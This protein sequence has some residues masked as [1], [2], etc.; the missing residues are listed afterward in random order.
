MKR[1]ETASDFHRRFTNDNSVPGRFN[2]YKK[3]PCSTTP[4]P[5]NRRDF[6]KISLVTSGE[7]ILSY[8]DR[9]FHVKDSVVAF[10]NPMVP[11]S[12]EPISQ[13][14]SGYFCLF[15]EEFINPHL[16]ADSLAN[17]PLFKVGGTPVLVPNARAMQFLTGIFEQM[18]TEMQS[19]YA[20]KYELMRSY[21]QI[22][23]HEA[24]KIEPLE[25]THQPGNSAVRLSARFME[26]LE[27]QFPIAASGQ[28]MEL[29]NAGEFAEALSVH[30]NHLN[31]VLKEIT[32]KTTSELLAARVLREA[33]DL[34]MHSNLDITEISY[35]LGFKHASNF[36]IFFKK[37]TDQTPQRFRRQHVSIS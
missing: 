35:C 28:T 19:S 34:L 37:Q 8:A 7:G 16:T 9:A 17:S 27:R 26:L 18:L 31:R 36:N 12:W 30:T 10:S 33:R 11:Y 23:I 2:V 6:Y 14:N 1:K 3:E 29:K 32:G 21:V 20:N 13:D 24:L 15:T 22:I 25:N 4:I 5:H